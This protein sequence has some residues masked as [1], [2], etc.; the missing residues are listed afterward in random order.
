MKGHIAKN[1]SNS[2]TEKF[3]FN[4]AYFNIRYIILEQNNGVRKYLGTCCSQGL[5]D[6]NIFFLEIF[7]LVVAPT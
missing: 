5:V 7:V 3:T 1:V 6:V 2:R 4:F